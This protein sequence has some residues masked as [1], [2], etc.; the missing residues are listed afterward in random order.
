MLCFTV[1]QEPMSEPIIKAISRNPLPV[2]L[3]YFAALFLIM[4]VVISG[5]SALIYL[6]ASSYLPGGVTQDI[7]NGMLVPV[8]ASLALL[9]AISGVVSWFLGSFIARRTQAMAQ[10]RL[11]TQLLNISPDSIY[12]HD[13]QGKCLYANEAALKMGDIACGTSGDA[14]RLKD[15]VRLTVLD[16]GHIKQVLER[17]DLTFEVS[18]VRKDGSTGLVEVHSRAVQ[19]A[20]NKFVISSARDVTERKKIEE[21][22]RRSSETV[23]YT[24]LTL[25]T[26]L[27][28]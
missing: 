17:G 8:T 25:P 22:L 21:E 24:H 7:F 28:V 11:Y 27:R 16:G 23:S 9:V 26:I 1:E 2:A 6:Q 20:A 19:S 3:L 10:L 5:I 14:W 12:L 13:T 18:Q 4:V 15:A